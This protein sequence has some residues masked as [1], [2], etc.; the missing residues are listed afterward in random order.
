MPLWLAS[1]VHQELA[2]TH[3][4]HHALTVTTDVHHGLAVTISVGNDPG[5][6]TDVQNAQAETIDVYQHSS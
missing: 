1:D 6:M 2:Q 5:G 3:D 4:V